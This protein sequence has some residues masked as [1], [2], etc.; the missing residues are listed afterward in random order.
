MMDSTISFL[1]PGLGDN[2]YMCKFLVVN[3]VIFIVKIRLF[4]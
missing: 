4:L 3:F 1:N 2:G